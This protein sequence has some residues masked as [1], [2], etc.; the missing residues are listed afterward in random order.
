M[1]DLAAVRPQTLSLVP[2]TMEEAIKFSS[3]LAKSDLVP[4]D[5]VDKPANIL[6]AIQW[7]LEFGLQPMQAMQS[8]AVINGRPSLWGDAVIAL[9]RASEVCEYIYEEIAPDGNSATC[10]TK[11]K[12]E[13]EQ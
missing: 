10:R 8:I 5:F 2:R 12:G 3:T 1:N 13:E 6:V 9:V 4:K 7:G 11:R